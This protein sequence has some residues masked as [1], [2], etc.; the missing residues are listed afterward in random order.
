MRIRISAT[1]ESRNLS[2]RDLPPQKIDRYPQLGTQ[3]NY[4]LSIKERADTKRGTISFVVVQNFPNPFA[5]DA[6]NLDSYQSRSFDHSRVPILE[7][8]QAP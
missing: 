3:E 2:S 4:L 5:E 7:E 8:Q 1:P 6:I